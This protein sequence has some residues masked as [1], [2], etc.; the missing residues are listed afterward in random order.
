MPKAISHDQL[1]RKRAHHQ[2]FAGMIRC[3]SLWSNAVSKQNEH[4]IKF[5]RNDILAGSIEI[6]PELRHHMRNREDYFLFNV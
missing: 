5:F 2:M 6:T 4:Q 3:R 1:A